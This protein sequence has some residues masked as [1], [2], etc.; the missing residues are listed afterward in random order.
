MAIFLHVFMDMNT[1]TYTYPPT[2]HFQAAIRDHRSQ[3]KLSFCLNKLQ[4]LLAFLAQ[5]Q[6]L[7][8]SAGSSGAQGGSRGVLELAEEGSAAVSEPIYSC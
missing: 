3:R 8:A 1:H 6:H 7:S 2:H 4:N 5:L